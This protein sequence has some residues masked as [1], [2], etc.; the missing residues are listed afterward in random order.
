M[1]ANFDDFP[2]LSRP[3]QDCVVRGTGLSNV[4]TKVQK[5]VLGMDPLYVMPLTTRLP[6]LGLYFVTT[7]KNR[8]AKKAQSLV[9]Y[10]CLL[11]PKLSG[12][13]PQTAVIEWG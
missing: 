3:L 5:V 11:E 7:A 13:E 6:Q 2:T 9:Q 4:Q 12:Q 1:I 10:R 8:L